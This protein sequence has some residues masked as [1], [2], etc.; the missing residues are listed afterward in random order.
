MKHIRL[1]LIAII[2]LIVMSA[3]A[4][5][6]EVDGIYYQITSSSE[7]YE[8]G[9]TCNNG[10]GNS[11]SGHIIVPDYVYY[12]SNRYVVTTI[13]GAHGY[14][15]GAFSKCIELVSVEMPNSIRI[16]ESGAF[17]NCKGLTTLTIPQSVEYI[18]DRAFMGC[19]ELTVVN[20]NAISADADYSVVSNVS[21]V[22][23]GCSSVRTLN[24]GEGVKSLPKG[25]FRGMAGLTSVSIPNSVTSMGDEVFSSCTGLVSI[26]L[27]NSLRTIEKD[28]FSN[29]TGLITVIIPNSVTSIGKSAFYGCSGLTNIVLGNSLTII[30]EDAFRDCNGLTSI[31]FPNSLTDIG[32]AAFRDCNGLTS[33]DFPNSLTDIGEAAFKGCCGLTSINLPNSVTSIGF[34]A[35]MGCS[36]LY[37]IN[38]A[39]GNPVYDSRNNCNA[40]IETTTDILIVGC[41]T[42]VIPNSVTSIGDNAFY[43]CCGLTNI[44]IPNSVM[45]IWSYAFYGCSSLSS[46]SIPNSVEWIFAMAFADCNNLTSI[47]ISK[48]VEYIEF[49]AFSGCSSLNTIIV[50]SD[51][52]FYDSR[53]NCNA[54]ITSLTNKL[55]VG[56]K[57][58]I[59]P[60]SVTTIGSYAFSGCSGLTRIDI[61][62]SVTSILNGAFSNCTSLASITIPNSVTTIGSSA[63]FG[64][65]SLMTINLPNSLM[66]IGVAAFKDTGVYNEES[67]WENN[68]LYIG[69]YLLIA[70]EGFDLDYEVKTG[71]SLIADGAF[72][73]LFLTSISIP[74]S[75]TSIGRSTFYDCKRLT[76]I[77]LP[78][79]ITSIGDYA[80]YDCENL[81]NIVVYSTVPPTLGEGAFIGSEVAS[82]YVPCGSGEAYANAQNWSLF[83]NIIETDLTYAV[84]VHAN[85]E[86]LGSVQI[87][88]HPD[89][90]S[91]VATVLALPINESLFLNWSINGQVVS[92]NNPYT[93]VVN[94]DVELVAIFSGVG[95]EEESIQL[96][97]VSP[98]PAKDRIKVNCGDMR[99]ISLFS[100]DGSIIKTI[101][102]MD[103]NEMEINLSGLAK[104][105]YMLRIETQNGMMI[106]RKIIVQ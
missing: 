85:D 40:I 2:L 22:F 59:I 18:G 89:C 25:I 35:F 103:A 4:H 83:T 16:I 106:N 75:V 84:E 92:T 52:P 63:L 6:F 79:F 3:M 17:Y 64:C 104:G 88:Q 14:S 29:C 90:Q 76:T 71:T 98:N 55:V 62:N 38:V 54:I 1:L 28:V 7:P 102:V 23:I 82:L 15:N 48:S 53:N 42:T 32:E 96:V 93:F 101:N 49:D 78:D 74:N 57:T 87:P 5:D 30:G 94:E 36:G 80:F 8:V 10:Q 11:Y 100:L 33:I 19:T 21:N 81:A 91:H 51:N 73:H 39:G 26:E 77:S 13:V 41:N 60:N 9:V 12:E 66:S 34:A 50:D 56:C 31:D 65:S 24:I 99:S 69:N 68:V 43:G 72:Q 58:T 44:I 61:P 46:I 45:S 70:R 95:L 27:S 105:L 20:Y 37:S 47:S 86:S 67:N 97:S